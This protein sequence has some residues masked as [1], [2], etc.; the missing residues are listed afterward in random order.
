M[1]TCFWAV[2]KSSEHS[3]NRNHRFRECLIE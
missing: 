1:I 2:S 3:S